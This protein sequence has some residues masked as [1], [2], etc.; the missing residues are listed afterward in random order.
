MGLGLLGRGLGVIKFLAECG[1]D[2]TVTDLKSKEEL[3]SSLKKLSKYKNIKYVLGEHRLEDFRGKDMVVRAPN[4]PLDSIY[5]AEARK[6]KIPVE[7]DASLFTKLAPQGVL[8]IGVTGTRGK[9]TVTHMLYEV[10]F[11]GKKKVY[12]GGNVRG[13]ATL[14]LLKKVNPP[15]GGGDIVLMELDSWQSQGFGEA[16]ISP[17]ISVFTTFMNDHMNYY[18]GDMD[19]YFIDKANLFKY[20]KAGDVAIV[21]EQV[22]Q[23]FTRLRPPTSPLLRRGKE[24]SVV[25][26]KAG[27]KNLPS[28]WKLKI[29]GEHNRYNAGLVVVVAR[30]LGIADKVIKKAVESFAGVSGRLELVREVGGVKYFNDTTATSPDG[31]F[32]ALKALENK[33]GKIILLA[34]GTDANLDLSQVGKEVSKY[35][36]ALILFKGT[37]TDQIL[38]QLPKKPKFPV[39]VV[40]SMVDA[41][42]LAKGLAKKGDIVLLSPG[43]KSFG[44][45]KNEFDRGDQFVKGVKKIK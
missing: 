25:A 8:T 28:N 6:N 16:Q 43:A 22:W 30:E 33:K 20:Q 32:S 2:L 13:L 41:L 1:A 40:E 31:L 23:K 45:F 34:G 19:R 21:G 3:E 36:K 15:A 24:G 11:A 44:V 4:A 35:V 7:M 42:K 12:L 38:L 17:N 5:L 37:A 9:S 10:L 14:P 39:E 29:I 27:S 18:K 26:K